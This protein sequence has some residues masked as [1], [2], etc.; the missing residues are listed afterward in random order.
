MGARPT[1][2]GAVFPSLV[3]ITDSVLVRKGTIKWQRLCT[4]AS[5]LRC[6]SASPRG[7]KDSNYNT[8]NVKRSAS[9]LA[10][11]C[12]VSTPASEPPRGVALSSVVSVLPAPLGPVKARRSFAACV[13]ALVWESSFLPAAL[14]GAAGGVVVGLRGGIHLGL[15][16]CGQRPLFCEDLQEPAHQLVIAMP[17][18]GAA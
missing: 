4:L 6:E 10:K 18:L 8:S 5:T 17:R 11:P 12:S 16:G 3:S 2:R 13:V 7:W 9:V 14:G 1:R 15:S